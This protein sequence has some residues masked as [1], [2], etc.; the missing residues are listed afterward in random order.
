MGGG[1]K[2]AT[3]TPSPRATL[4]TDAAQSKASSGG[5]RIGENINS[6]TGKTRKG[7]K[8]NLD[9]IGPLSDKSAGK[10]HSCQQASG[11]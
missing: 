1:E 9:L 10:A 7:R 11:S 5:L 4:G 3:A 2:L 8:T 6:F